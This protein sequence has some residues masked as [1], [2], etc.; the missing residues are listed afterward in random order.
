MCTCFGIV[1]RINDL[2]S[3]Q[4]IWGQRNILHFKFLMKLKRQ[5]HI[6]DWKLNLKPI[7]SFVITE[8]FVTHHIR[9]LNTKLVPLSMK[10][11]QINVNPGVN[12]IHRVNLL[13][14]GRCSPAFFTAA[15][16]L[17][18]EGYFKTVTIHLSKIPIWKY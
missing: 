8:I 10:S 16:D 5:K 4:F 2:I 18:V 3:F 14:P 12:S 6:E 15:L 7:L 9:I 13:L 1:C 11:H 17:I